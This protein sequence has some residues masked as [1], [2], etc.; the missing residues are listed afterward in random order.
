M[1]GSFFF[2][3]VPLFVLSATSVPASLIYLHRI[4]S[5]DP[6]SFHIDD[7]KDIRSEKPRALHR[8]VP[9]LFDGR[10]PANHQKCNQTLQIIG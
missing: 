6:P 5:I 9:L 4:P 2:T 8:I 3:T 7:H 1:Q 10:N